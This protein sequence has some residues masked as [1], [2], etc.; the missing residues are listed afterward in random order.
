MNIINDNSDYLDKLFDNVYAYPDINDNEFQEKIFKKKEF[1]NYQVKHRPEINTYNDLKEYRKKATAQFKLAEYQQMLSNY[2]NPDTPFN[3]LLLFHGLG[4]GKT[5]CAINIASRFYEQIRKYNTRIHILVPGPILKENWINEIKNSVCS[6]LKDA[7]EKQIFELFN[8][9]SYKAFN[10]RVLGEK[11][12]NKDF[13]LTKQSKYKK[14]EEGEFMRNES[15]NK[16]DNLDNSLLII[17][18]A[19]NITRNDYGNAVKKI[20]AVSKNL[21]ILLLTGTPM[22]NAADDI[23]SLI[24]IMDI[25]NKHYTKRP[26]IFTGNNHTLD[27]V[28]GGEERL[29]EAVKGK[30]SYIAGGDKYLFAVRNDI[31]VIPKS[32]KFTKVIPVKFNKEQYDFYRDV[33][34]END[35]GLEKRSNDV[36]NFIFP[37]LSFNDKETFIEYSYGKEG[38]E[39]AI[40]NVESNPKEYN[41]ALAKYINKYNDIKTKDNNLIY[42]T[43]K[44]LTGKFLY[45]DYLKLFSPKFY[46]ALT[47]IQNLVEGKKG[48][49]TAFVYSNIVKVGIN[50]FKQVLLQNGYIEFDESVEKTINNANDETVCYYCGVCKKNHKANHPYYPSTFIVITGDKDD[51]DNDEE[52]RNK[53][54]KI[55][56]DVFSSNENREGKYIKLVLGSKVIAEG[57][58]TKNLMEVHILDV[59]YNFARVDQVVG[60]AI[61]KNSHRYLYSESNPY[62]VVD[63]YKYCM[64]EDKPTNEELLYQKAEKKHAMIKYVERIIKQEAVD[65]YLNYEWNN[66]PIEKCVSLKHGDEYDKQVLNDK[67]KLNVCKPE[68][69][70]IETSYLTKQDKEYV[71][72]INNNKKLVDINTFT[73]NMIKYEIDNCKEIIKSMYLFKYAY[74]L[75]EITT[76]VKNKYDESNFEMYYIYK[77]LDDLVPTND[78]DF[79]N[80]DNNII[81]DK[82]NKPGYLIYINNYYIFQPISQN[83]N[84]PMYYRTKGNDVIEEGKSLLNYLN[85]NNIIDNVIVSNDKEYDFISVSNYYNNRKQND[86]I[87]VI[88][89]EP[90]IKGNRKYSELKDTFKI[91]DKININSNLKRQTGLQSYTGA[92]CYNAY[93]YNDL[94]RKLKK[95]NINLTKDELAKKSRGLVCNKM[96][97]VLLNLEKYSEDNTTYCIIPENHPIYEFPYNLK[98]RSKF[99]VNKISEKFNVNINVEKIKEVRGYKISC[100]DSKDIDKQF[101]I[102]NKFELNGKSWIRII[103]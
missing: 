72:S 84:I 96:K 6:S 55:I 17:D 7:S 12:R 66:K 74:S 93:G 82:F 32:L 45:R 68:N 76:F 23:I 75:N 11:I 63:V 24:E 54:K 79:N 22:K 59:Y 65:K 48:P 2:F 102:E 87:G 88:D 19:H 4:T 89:K 9:L 20:A 73:N 44:T 36:C 69:D 56:E 42:L 50:I 99:I 49:R 3:S 57:Y 15:F 8:I 27:F 35:N 5:C 51:D 10:K 31:G 71:D 98:D 47:N 14:N 62:P 80:I 52:E 28:D 13:K 100:M 43:N 21:K 90:N 33:V 78:N 16:I 58:N 77:A 70:Y 97:E 30:F 85:D 103:N 41:E 38:L 53:Q 18:E 60:R 67:E 39:E 91:R 92:V 29:R 46:T 83:E 37:K 101:M 81:I 26:Q 64:V 34:D 95:L 86:I 1:F 94:L 40:V 61:R 25:A